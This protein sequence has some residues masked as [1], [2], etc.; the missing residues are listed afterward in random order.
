MKKIIKE[1]LDEYR[2]RWNTDSINVKEVITDSELDSVA[3]KLESV[4]L[5]RGR[6]IEFDEEI[7]NG[8]KA[9][10]SWVCDICGKNTYDVEWDYMGSGTNHIGCELKI[11]MG[12][13]FIDESNKNPV[14]KQHER[15]RREKNRL[16]EEIVDNKGEGYIYESTD[17]GETVYKRDFGSYVKELAVHH[18]VEN[19][20]VH[21]YL[22]SDRR[23]E[24]E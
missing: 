12:E 7:I 18:E 5:D 13:K 1:V 17:G 9:R 4:L 23:K 19:K 24:N 10:E 21:E 6:W 16:A 14:P 2:S 3:E 8:Q 15:I 22:S 20:D 11:E